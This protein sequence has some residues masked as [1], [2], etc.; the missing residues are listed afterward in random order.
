[1]RPRIAFLTGQSDPGRCALSPVQCAT[2]DALAPHAGDIDLLPHNFPWTADTAPWRPVPLLRASVANGR[3]YLAARGGD[4]PDLSTSAREAARAHLLA[5]P[6]T[7]LLVG[8]CGLALL[9]ALIA[10]FD[11]AQRARLRAVSYGGV[12]PRWPAGIHGTQLRGRRD[13][14][15]AWLGPA[16]G[17]RPIVVDHGHMD[18]LGGNGVVEA[19]RAHVAWLRGAA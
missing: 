19:A 11:I 12:A 18:Y 3:Q 14:I 10:P 7:L 17:P 16:N 8:S 1:M 2:L 5:A 15:A 13:R 6:R 4:V 9:N